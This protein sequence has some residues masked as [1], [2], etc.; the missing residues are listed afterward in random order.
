MRINTQNQIPEIVYVVAW[1]YESGGGFDW[2]VRK[3]DADL[4]WRKEK[5]SADDPLLAREGWTAYRFEYR[6]NARTC[7]TVTAEIDEQ[8]I[9][10][11][12]NAAE[13]YRARVP[14]QLLEVPTYYSDRRVDF[15]S[16]FVPVLIREAD[17]VRVILG[18]HDPDAHSADIQVERRPGGCRRV[19]ASWRAERNSW[20][21]CSCD[22][23]TL[24]V[25]GVSTMLATLRN[26]A[27]E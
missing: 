15:A 21:A 8:I 27:S 2:Y 19:S 24:R 5:E 13:R 12:S 11:C 9:A 17:G 26:S 16:P 10:L 6:P 22:S 14:D 7:P 1:S 18:S 25:P 20:I 3:E 23:I 4:A